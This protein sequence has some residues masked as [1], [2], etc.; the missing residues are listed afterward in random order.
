M[1]APLLQDASLLSPFP[2]PRWADYV[3]QGNWAEN[4]IVDRE[5]AARVTERELVNYIVS[6]RDESEDHRAPLHVYWDWYDALFHLEAY[7]DD[8]QAWQTQVAIPEIR[9][10][11]RVAKSI[12][13]ASLVDAPEFFKLFAYKLWEEPDVRMIQRWLQYAQQQAGLVD[14]YTDALEEGLLYGSG[15]MA[16]SMEDYVSHK[17]RMQEPDQQ[18]IQQW[19]QQAQWAMQTGQQPPPQ[20]MP[21]MVAVPEARNKYVWK[22]KPIRDVYPDPFAECGDFYRGRYVVEYS[23]ADED[24]LWERAAVGMYDGI[25]DIGEPSR[26]HYH[27]DLRT[28]PDDKTRNGRKRHGILEFQGDIIIEGKLIAREWMGTVVNE[29]AL[30]RCAPNP[31]VTKKRRYIWT[32]PIRRRN[33]VWGDALIDADAHVQVTVTKLLDLMIDSGSFSVLNAFNWDSSKSDEPQPPDSISPGMIIPSSNG[34]ALTKIDFGSRA[35][36]LWPIIQQLMD[37]GGKSTQISEWADGQPT[38]KGRPSAA[39]VT[40]KTAA[41]Q[42]HLNN[43][44]R[45]LERH[46]LERA[47]QLQMD[48]IVQFGGDKDDPRLADLLQEWGGPQALLDERYRLMLLTKDYKIKVHGISTMLGH[49]SLISRLM[50]A[51][52]L[53]MQMGIPLQSQFEM[54]YMILGVL[55]FDPE[56]LKLPPSPDDLRM[57]MFM[58]AMQAQAAMQGG[59]GPGVGGPIQGGAPMMPSQAGSAPPTPQ[60]VMNQVQA[61][62][63]PMP[64]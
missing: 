51:Q 64:G 35:N 6:C 34:P 5:A 47:L 61:G 57:Q 21:Y 13:K 50:Q 52:Q 28:R 42:Q 37:W 56:Q 16:L 26:S 63:P 60:A 24:V 48:Y 40:S 44:M 30:V 29:R 39:E 58:Q 8:K 31:V 9:T 59:A 27:R 12:L 18:A 15:V 14:A 45:D 10:K 38:S 49:E 3:E 36:E 1:A 22:Y 4:G 33:R 23:E 19:M 17:P 54:Y 7:D 25:D 11:I 20:P 46:D 2:R 53:A 32:T 55:G 41:G 43:T 62:G